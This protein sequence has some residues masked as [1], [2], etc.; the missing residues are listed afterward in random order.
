MTVG[1]IAKIRSQHELSGLATAALE[2]LDWFSLGVMLVDNKAY[3]LACNRRADQLIREAD[4]L[5]V[6]PDG[7]IGSHQGWTSRL[8]ALIGDAAA[9]PTKEGPKSGRT[10]LLPR[11]TGRRPLSVLAVPLSEHNL[12][13][14]HEEPAAIVFVGD[15]EHHRATNQAWL[16]GLYEFTPAEARLAGLIVQGNS[17]SEAAA[18]LAI[19]VG[20][21]RI[22]LKHIF[23]KTGTRRQAELVWLVLSGPTQL[24]L[25]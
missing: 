6:A 20:T 16:Q 1:V 19:S 15:P 12:L 24:L 8:R 13:L 9:K 10:I 17:L 25:E 21:A 23:S 3:L 14:N 22:H 11:S 18:S 5:V 4:G 7:L 2:A